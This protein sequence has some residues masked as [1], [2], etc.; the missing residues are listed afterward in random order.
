MAA[1]V[2]PKYWRS[3]VLNYI[4]FLDSDEAMKLEIDCEAEKLNYLLLIGDA[5]RAA[6]ILREQGEDLEAQAVLALAESGY[7]NDIVKKWKD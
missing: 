2:T 4:K 6:E 1:Q 5:A 7:L 3:C